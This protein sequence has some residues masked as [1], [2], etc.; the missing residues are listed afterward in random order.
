M[1]ASIR[2]P[3]A[4]RVTSSKA[5]LARVK[6]TLVRH[7]LTSSPFPS[8]QMLITAPPQK[9]LQKESQRSELLGSGRSRGDPSLADEPYSDRDDTR[10]RLLRGTETLAD[11]MSY[12]IH[13]LTPFFDIASSIPFPF[14]GATPLLL[15]HGLHI[16]S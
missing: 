10:E 2:G 3:Y 4:A 8:P 6:K 14:F 7:P 15:R 1:P 16:Q 5:E 11:G 12:L 9:D 13:L